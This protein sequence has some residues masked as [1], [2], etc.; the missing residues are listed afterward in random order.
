[1]TSTALK[2]CA[3]GGL[4]LDSSGLV[5]GCCDPCELSIDMERDR[6]QRIASLFDFVEY[7]MGRITSHETDKD[8]D[9]IDRYYDC[10]VA[11]YYAYVA[12]GAQTY[13]LEYFD[14]R[15]CEK[16]VIF[17]VNEYPENKYVFTADPLICSVCELCGENKGK[18]GYMETNYFEINGVSCTED[19]DRT[20]P[21][22]IGIYNQTE[23]ANTHP[24]FKGCVWWEMISENC[25]AWYGVDHSCV[26]YE[27]CR[28]QICEPFIAGR[29]KVVFDFKLYDYQ[30]V[31]EEW[32]G[33]VRECVLGDPSDGWL[34]PIY[35]FDSLAELF[36]YVD[37]VETSTQSA[38][39]TITAGV[40]QDGNCALFVDGVETFEERFDWKLQ[41]YEYLGDCE[42][43]SHP[44]YPSNNTRSI[45]DEVQ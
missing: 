36:D 22:V 19:C 15:E 16:K 27:I 7:G 30:M 35:C 4:K 33:F 45:E 31:K 40:G 37:Y 5:L 11:F 18:S 14:C 9:P 26:V 43:E 39:H 17:R 42:G 3:N 32:H 8:G 20:K 2:L 21:H 25:R 13:V 24:D 28:Q 10:R 44:S 23:Y 6:I 38:L 29:Y 41:R 12:D 34:D 1:M